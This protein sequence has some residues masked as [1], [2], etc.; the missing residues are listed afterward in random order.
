MVPQ[1]NNTVSDQACLL[2]M[3]AY[4]SCSF[5]AFLLNSSSS[6]S[7]QRKDELGQ[8]PAILIS[9]LVN[10]AYILKVNSYM[11]KEFKAACKGN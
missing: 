5:F 2:M 6:R 4:W 11:N 9:R 1:E 7:Q 3:A 8:Y 10:N